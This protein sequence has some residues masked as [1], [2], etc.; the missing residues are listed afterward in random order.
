MEPMISQ[1]AATVAL[2]IVVSI[3]ALIIAFRYAISPAIITLIEDKTKEANEA[4]SRGMS[5]MGNVGREAKDIKKMEKLMVTDIMEEYP[6]IELALEYFSPETAELIK[7][8][9]ER[10]LKLLTRYKPLIDAFMGVNPA[11]TREIYDL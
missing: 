6:E 11:Q 9:P 2:S 4:I 5:S 3:T 1:I 8:H 7:K 10:A